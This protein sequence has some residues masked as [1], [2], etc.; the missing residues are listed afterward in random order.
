MTIT[1]RDLTSRNVHMTFKANMGVGRHGWLRLTP[2]YGVRLVRERIEKLPEGSVVTDPFSGTGTTPLAAAELGLFGQSVDVNPFLIWLGTVKTRNYTEETLIA[3]LEAARDVHATAARHKSDDDLWTPNLFKIEK[4]WGTSELHAI[5]AL[6]AAIDGYKDEV[7]DLLDI[8]LCR[9]LIST[10]NAAF[11]HQSMSFKDGST[12]GTLFD[13]DE[14]GLTLAAFVTEVK[15]VVDSARYDLLG[16]ATISLGDSRRGL[17]E[18]RKADLVL[19]SPPYVNRMSYIRELRPY[20]Y[21]L[22]F[23]DQASD[24]GNLDWQAIGGTWG[25]ATSKLTTWT[26][27]VETP[28]D[29]AMGEVCESI[30]EDGGK[31]GSLLATY[32]HKYFHDMWFH[33]QAITG[34]VKPGG[35]VSY[36]VGNSTFYGHEV[37]AH[38]WY[39]D[40][41]KA[42]GYES[43]LVDTIRKRNS[44]K[45]LFE[46]EVTG[47][48][49]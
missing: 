25:T 11:N 9:S 29:A 16:S 20:M 49:P 23:L 1:A 43:V 42:L 44:N 45:A 2:A 7:R 13:H 8:A 33:F 6:R 19:T 32:V 37:P 17:S 24:A 22:R 14:V 10:S 5:K 3:A 41:I 34:Q 38:L 21:W 15:T 39:A 48:R 26:P 27:E 4:W 40:L 36:I 12:V 47:I 46:Y 30:R 18:L 31:N 35:R 28:I